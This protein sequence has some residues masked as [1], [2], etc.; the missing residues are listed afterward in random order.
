M[1]KKEM[2][3]MHGTWCMNRSKLV[4][5]QLMHKANARGDK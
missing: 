1:T 3:K 5:A 2:R 4:D